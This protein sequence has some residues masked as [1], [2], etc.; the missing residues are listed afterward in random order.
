VK[1][2]RIEESAASYVVEPRR[3]ATNSLNAKGE[4]RLRLA[5]RDSAALRT[6]LNILATWGL[7]GE[8]TSV[9]LGTPLRTVYSWREKIKNGGSL[10]EPLAVDTVE[11]LSYILGVWEATMILLPSEAEA[12][13]FLQSPNE[14]AVFGGRSPLQRML[15]GQVADL[16]VVR[17]WFDGWRG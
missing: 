15:D 9:I 16:T 4:E 5:G 13:K 6:V 10:K 8:Q 14:S 3:A 17:R 2:R 1:L 11:R 7:N 12:S